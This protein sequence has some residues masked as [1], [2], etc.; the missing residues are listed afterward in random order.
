MTKDENKKIIVDNKRNRYWDIVK[1]FGI[2]CI[3]LGHVCCPI[4][5]RKFVYTF[6]LVIF[7]FVAGYFYNEDKYGNKPGEYF[8]A[9]FKNMWGKYFFYTCILVLLHNVFLYFKFYNDGQYYTFSNYISAISHNL[10][11]MCA[12][13]FSSALWFV[14]VLII[15]NGIFASII[16]ISRKIC[17]IINKEKISI[18]YISIIIITCLFGIIGTF[19]NENKQEI[20]LQIHTVY[21]VLPIYMI[22]YFFKILINK[23]EENI[24]KIKWYIYLILSILSGIFLYYIVKNGMEI[25]L[26]QEEIINSYMFYIV[27]IVGIIFCLSISKIIEKLPMIRNVFSVMGKHSFTIMALHFVFIKLGEIGYMSIL[28]ISN[29]EIIKNFFISN[30]GMIW[31]FYMIIG[32]TIPTCI[33][34]LIDKMKNNIKRF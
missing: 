29:L 24:K 15:A 10:V 30:S 17:L 22:A 12:E 6:H 7:F 28:K 33:S 4:M 16:F 9:R 27:S 14:A 8:A 5:L 25:E 18:K 11:F 3:V 34:I 21:L 13:P 26:A 32:A 1:G 31:I 19:L 2:L 23:Y 20:I